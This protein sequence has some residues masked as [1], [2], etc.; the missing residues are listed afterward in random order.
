[1]LTLLICSIIFCE[2]AA[3]YGVIIAIIMQTKLQ[4]VDPLESGP[5]PRSAV[6]AGYAIL[7]AGLTTGFS[8]MACGYADASLH[9]CL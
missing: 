1:M 9:S 6:H 3:I 7:A 5:Y 2:A 4:R 8:N